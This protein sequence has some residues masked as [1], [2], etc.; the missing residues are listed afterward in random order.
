MPYTKN[1]AT[2]RFT[3]SVTRDPKS[4][5]A[6]SNTLVISTNADEGSKYATGTTS[7][8]MSVKEAK[9][10]RNFLNNEFG[11]MPASSVVVD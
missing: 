4:H 8:T 6:G 5:K 2:K 11:S 1:Q 7:V 9:V 10:L 3:Y